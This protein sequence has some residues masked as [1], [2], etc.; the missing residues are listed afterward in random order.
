M[1][2]VLK[3]TESTEMLT[4]SSENY[5]R[6]GQSRL[7][8]FAMLARGVRMCNM[9]LGDAR[10]SGRSPLD[11]GKASMRSVPLSDP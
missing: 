5:V 3:S 1:E 8:G 2:N 11:L 4:R 10:N 7:G 9:Q 6:E